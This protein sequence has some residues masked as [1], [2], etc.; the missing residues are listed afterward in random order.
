MPN[1]KNLT[2]NTASLKCIVVG[3]AGSG[4]SVFASTFPTPAFL[5]DFD[6]GALTYRGLDI[7][8]EQFD[9]TAQGW[10]KFEKVFA[11][12]VKAV[13]E[14]KYKTV[15]FDSASTLTDLAMERAMALDPKRSATGGPLWNVHYQM[16]KNLV[17]GRIQKFINLPCNLVLTAHLNIVT[18]QE[19][20]AVIDV[21]PL[22]TG[23]LSTKIPGLFDEVYYA[24][25][26]TKGGQ[27]HWVLQTVPKGMYAARSRISGAQRLLP[28]FVPN[29][30]D[31]IMK[32]ATSTK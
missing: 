22:F 18:D 2:V 29:S 9:L 26:Q 11:E 12:V 19:S 7:D 23:T 24:T 31:A 25:A 30:Y 3:K 17:E 21:T 14:G 20:G 15:I 28:D 4:K 1:A 10:V 8:Y 16:V 6:K 27:T 13:S 5:F 32:L